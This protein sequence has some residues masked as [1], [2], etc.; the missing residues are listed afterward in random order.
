MPIYDEDDYIK[1]SLLGRSEH[2]SEI[3]V[4]SEGEESDGVDVLYSYFK[5]LCDD[6]QMPIEYD[7]TDRQTY[8]M[9]MWELYQTPFVVIIPRDENRVIDGLEL[10]AI[11]SNYITRY[12]DYSSIDRPFCSVLELM[13]GMARRIDRDLLRGPDD[14]DRYHKWFRIMLENMGV[15]KYDDE[16]FLFGCK[17]EVD[18]ILYEIVF[19][20]EK[21]AKMAKKA[22][23][24]ANF[25]KISGHENEEIWYQFSH[26]YAQNPEKFA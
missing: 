25:W 1:T 2:I 6:V 26:F 19:K 11:F 18:D 4:R 16:H 15:F 23:Q 24:M 5:W 3:A 21:N 22:G 10:R 12:R 13:I 9:L 20:S 17:R 14:P 7:G 8:F